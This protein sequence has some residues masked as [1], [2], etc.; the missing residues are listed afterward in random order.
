VLLKSNLSANPLVYKML[1]HGIATNDIKYVQDAIKHGALVDK[2][3]LSDGLNP[4]MIAAKNCD[5][6]VVHEML[7]TNPSVALKDSN[8]RTVFSFACANK[9]PN[10]LNILIKYGIKF[11]QEKLL[12]FLLTSSSRYVG[13]WSLLMV[14]SY[15]NHYDNARQIIDALIASKNISADDIIKY[16]NLKDKKGRTSLHFASENGNSKLVE[17]LIN[18]GANVNA[19]DMNEQTPLHF[20]ANAANSK[21]AGSGNLEVKKVIDLLI[22]HDV[23]VDK[24]D[25]NNKTVQQ[26]LIEF[27]KK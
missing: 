1:M 22:K 11:Y 21:V 9:D 27:C 5:S 26:I 25:K 3:I 16:V 24:K 15:N 23:D 18:Y 4:L 10:V 7:Q 13:G 14:A 19:L 20:I 12:T 2:Q 6:K 17:F 8:N